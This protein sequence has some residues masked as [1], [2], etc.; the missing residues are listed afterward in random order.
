MLDAI[1]RVMISRYALRHTR[2]PRFAHITLITQV[3][4]LMI[5]YLCWTVH[6][7]LLLSRSTQD[8]LDK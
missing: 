5:S 6:F 8:A 2:D 4:Y 7:T 3:L 1:M